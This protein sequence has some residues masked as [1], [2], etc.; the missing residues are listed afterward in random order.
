MS[1]KVK[2]RQVTRKKQWLD[3]LSLAMAADHDHAGRQH[4]IRRGAGRRA[5]DNRRS[6]GRSRP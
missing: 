1:S 3:C 6:A 4:R 5:T 2:R